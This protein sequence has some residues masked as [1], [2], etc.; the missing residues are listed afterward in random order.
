M[1]RSLPIG[2]KLTAWYAVWMAAAL[3]ALGILAFLSMRHSI[4]ATVDEQ[5]RD[6]MN[7]VQQT[8]DHSLRAGSVDILRR[9]LDED[10]ELRPQID[11]LQIWNDQGS[12][13]YQSMPLKTKGLPAPGT[14]SKRAK[15]IWIGDDP[16][17]VLE[18]PVTVNER[19]YRVQAA[20]RME[21]FYE[22]LGRFRSRLL[23]FTPLALLLAS[24]LGYWM[25]R[26]ALAPVDQITQAAQQ[27]SARNLSARL[28]VPPSG[29][30]LQRLAETLNQMLERIEVALD[31][32]TR[33][34]ADASHE[35]R[36]PITV[37]RTR[38]ELAL[39]RPRTAAEDRQTVEQLHSELVRASEL[40]DNLM[41]LARADSGAEQLRFEPANIGH[42]LKDVLAQVSPIADEKGVALEGALPGHAIWIAGDLQ[43]LQRLF[44]ILIEN[45]VKYT[46]KSGLV[47]VA[48]GTTNGNATVKIRDTG[49]GISEEDLPHIFDRFYRA[50]KARSRELGG[51]GLGLSIGRWIAEVHGGSV[52]VESR[53]GAGSTFQVVLPTSGDH[54]S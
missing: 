23:L 29:D 6:R 34:S 35:L 30:E 8:V 27:I 37:M 54:P 2:V 32:V 25:S 46:P 28:S 15:T 12:L 45:A 49:I 52:D 3:C 4:H 19:L 13:I 22:A 51:A 41:L 18:A 9:E 7:A 47:S 11:L 17:R 48:L 39:R 40:L 24:G 21:E 33:F 5:L 31:R 36:T 10:S 26:R 42:L 53:V 50:D 44:L 20:A 38:A 16:I 1:K 14:L 43:L